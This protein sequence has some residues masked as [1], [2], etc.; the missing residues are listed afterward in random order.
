MNSKKNSLKRSQKPLKRT[1]LNS[2]KKPLKKI[3]TSREK[4]LTQK[5]AE[6]EKMHQFF[7][8]IWNNRFHISEVSGDRLGHEPLTVYFHHILPKSKYKIAKFDEDNII[9]LTFDEHQKIE[10]NPNIYEEVNKRREFLLK[11]YGK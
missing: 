4:Q 7:N 11:K 2:K 5:A 3:S 10:N 1:P 9:L 6:L 8:D